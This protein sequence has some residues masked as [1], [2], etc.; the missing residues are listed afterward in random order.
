MGFKHDDK[1][2]EKVGDD[3]PIFVLRAQDRLAPQLVRDWLLRA[4]AYNGNLSRE[5]IKEAQDL[6][7]L[8]EDWQRENGSK[9]PD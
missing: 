2:L 5:K 6:A 7:D 9:F 3:E 4:K 1:C 8:M